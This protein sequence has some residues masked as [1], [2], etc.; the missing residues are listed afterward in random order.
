M[1][2]EYRRVLKICARPPGVPPP[3]RRLVIDA[4][5]YEKFWKNLMAPWL[6]A[7]YDQNTKN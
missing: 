7:Y 6:A 1:R 3:R 5:Y 4:P 2:V